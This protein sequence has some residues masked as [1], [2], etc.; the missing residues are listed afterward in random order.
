MP[1]DRWKIYWDFLVFLL[2]AYTVTLLP[3]NICF[4]PNGRDEPWHTIERAQ[5]VCWFL[6]IVFTFF[7]APKDK[8]NRII[9]SHKTIALMY[10]KSWF[11]IDLV[12]TFPWDLSNEWFFDNQ[13]DAVFNKNDHKLLRILRLNKIAKL[14]RMFRLVKIFR[15]F[16]FL[17]GKTNENFK[18]MYKFSQNVRSVLKIMVF[19]LI[20]THLMACLWF[21]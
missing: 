20:L 10:L 5:D 12:A 18:I 15:I 17:A 11:F 21:I 4:F 9:T 8:H 14:L 1:N 3:Y 6:D 19:Y 13:A 2:L 16:K 7:T